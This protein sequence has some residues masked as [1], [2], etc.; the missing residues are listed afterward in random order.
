MGKLPEYKYPLEIA[1]FTQQ[2]MLSV[3]TI[4]SKL[5]LNRYINYLSDNLNI[6]KK[7]INYYDNS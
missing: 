5:D 7:K 3:I 1:F 4:K 2:R 6:P